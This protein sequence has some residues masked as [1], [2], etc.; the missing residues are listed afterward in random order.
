MDNYLD[1]KPITDWTMVELIEMRELL[2]V[3]DNSAENETLYEQICS[4]IT[5]RQFA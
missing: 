1:D 4:E 5:R 3:P 2:D